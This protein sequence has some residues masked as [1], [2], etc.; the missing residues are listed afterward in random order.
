MGP[1]EGLVDAIFTYDEDIE[2][3]NGDLKKSSGIDL[4][5][6]EVF[7]VMLTSPGDWRLYPD[8]GA[9]PEEFIGQQNTRANAQR[10]ENHLIESLNP[11]V[12]PAN[13]NARVVPISREAVVV[14]IDIDVGD[15]TIAHIPMNFSYINGFVYTDFDDQ[16]DT[17]VPSKNIKINKDGYLKHPNPYWERLRRQ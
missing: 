2:F 1:F 6:R 16:V 7:K 10:L 17:I 8:T 11:V 4:I 15:M 3:S 9:S 13:I 14:Y 5:K 12:F